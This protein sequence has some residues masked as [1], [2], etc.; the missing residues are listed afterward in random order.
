MSELV[1]SFLREL[2]SFCEFRFGHF[3]ITVFVVATGIGAGPDKPTRTYVCHSDHLIRIPATIRICRPCERAHL[4][5]WFWSGIFLDLLRV[6][7]LF[8][9]R[10]FRNQFSFLALRHAFKQWHAMLSNR[11]SQDKKNKQSRYFVWLL[12][13]LRVLCVLWTWDKRQKRRISNFKSAAQL[14]SRFILLP[15][16]KLLWKNWTWT[17]QVPLSHW[18]TKKPEHLFVVR[19]LCLL[20]FGS[21]FYLSILDNFNHVFVLIGN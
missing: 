10:I 12:S 14:G 15:L 18:T 17:C 4:E 9:G 19:T 20:L 5:I 13:F 1:R 7:P 2:I 16:L 6:C 3:I 11:F 8:F 21:P